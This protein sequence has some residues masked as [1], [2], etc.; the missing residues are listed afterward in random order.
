MFVGFCET[1]LDIKPLFGGDEIRYL[2]YFN[3]S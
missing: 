2:V 3:M 1:Q